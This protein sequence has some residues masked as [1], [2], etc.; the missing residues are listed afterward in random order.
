MC[1]VAQARTERHFLDRSF[2]GVCVYVFVLVVSVCCCVV[3]DRRRLLVRE[4]HVRASVDTRQKPAN[5][6]YSRI[7]MDHNDGACGICTSSRIGIYGYSVLEN[8]Y[9]LDCTTLNT[10]NRAPIRIHDE[11]Q[12]LGTGT[13]RVDARSCLGVDPLWVLVFRWSLFLFLV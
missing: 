5:V 13:S 6:C 7:A 2:D 12:S 4:Y 3:S 9:S 1:V 8:T 10:H 11:I